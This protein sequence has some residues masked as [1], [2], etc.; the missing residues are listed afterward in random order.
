MNHTFTLEAH[1]DGTFSVVVN[2]ATREDANFSLDFFAPENIKKYRDNIADAIK[3]RYKDITVKAVKVMIAGVL[4]ATIPLSMMLSASAADR[5]SMAY[6][7]GGTAAQQIS[8][9]NRTNSAIQTVSPSYFDL[10]T[11]GS[12][13]LNTP[14]TQLINTMHGQNVRVVPYLSNHWDRAK[15]RAALNNYKQLA[16]DVAANIQKYNLDGVNVDIEN[17]TETSRAQYSAFMAELRRLIPADK[18]VSVAVAANPNGWNTGWHGSYDYKE[19]AK[20]SDYLMVM[21]YDEHW[22]GGDAGPVA[23]LSF[24]EKSIQYALKNTT[25]DKILVGLPFFGR[26]WSDDGRFVGDGLNLSTVDKLLAN[27]SATVTY[28]NASQSPKAEIVVKEGDPVSTVGG[29]ILAPGRYVVWYENDQSIAAKLALVEKYDLKGAGSWA[30]GQE[31]GS[32][33]NNYGNWIGGGTST[34]ATTAPDPSKEDP[35][36]SAT[37]DSAPSGAQTGNA[38]GIALRVNSRQAIVGGK[39]SGIDQ[40]GSSPYILGGRAM[41]P[42]R[43]T[44]EQMGASVKWVSNTK[45]VIIRYGS[46]VVSL[47][48]GSRTLTVTK[49]GVSTKREIDQAPVIKGGRVYVPL[50][51]VAEA[52]G[53]SVYYDDST[54]V[55]LMSE[56]PLTAAVRAAWV[57]DAASRL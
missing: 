12:L 3:A 57:Q 7:N 13:K 39:V 24:V 8:Y 48:A 25:P 54:R 16:A 29:R 30:L 20:S 34:T 33:W 49:N 37:A 28:D 43:F 5:Y 41:I 51:D 40:N 32:I 27:H 19:L 38:A 44:S 56:Q 50:R 26:I 35:A 45:P 47:T 10:N 17:V 55:V 11:D 18:E 36:G 53:F 1:D 15:G 21:T 6:F 4:V 46:T 22:N 52:L 14:S 2:Y 31:P 23:S 42:L 9:V